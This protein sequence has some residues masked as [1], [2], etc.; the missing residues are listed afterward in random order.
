MAKNDFYVKCDKCGGLGY[1]QGTTGPPNN[2][3]TQSK[4]DKCSTVG[5]LKA[6]NFS[7]EL[8]DDI[9]D[10]KDKVNDIKEK[11]DEM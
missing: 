2:T 11:I 3:P 8:I 5:Y 9:E 1:E 6:G 4:C 10:I 7:Q